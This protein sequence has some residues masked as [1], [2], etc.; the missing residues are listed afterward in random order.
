MTPFSIGDLLIGTATAALQI[1]GGDR[2]NNWYDW[3]QLPGAIKDGST[4][5]RA[6]DH[7]ARWREDTELMASLGLEV[8][9][10]GVEWSR[11]EPRP[12]EFDPA[13]I[14]HYRKEIGLLRE[15]G[16]APLVTLHHFT[17]PS[18][19]QGLGDWSHP[20]SV[21]IWLRFVRRVVSD[22]GDLVTEWVTL[23]EPNVYAVM[24]RLYG[25]FPPGHKSLPE[26]IKVMRHMAIAHCR[27]YE[28]IHE[29]QPHAT[30]GLAHHVRP[31]DPLKPVFTPMARLNSYLFQDALTDAV[32]GG[33]FALALGGQPKQVR[34]GKYYDYLGI[35]YYTRNAVVGFS[36][37]AFPN[38]PVNDLGWEIYPEGLARVAQDLHDRYPGPIWITENGT[39]DND[40]QFRARY[41]AEHLRVIAESKLPFERYYHWCF[42]DN[43]EW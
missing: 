10:M 40:E 8:Y 6:T 5:L 24:T 17:N 13:A 34:P 30:V 3:A 2:N 41:L 38:K 19:F 11:I 37:R 12:G 21:N 25:E 16:I 43:F 26:T 22:L 27:A 32:L 18:W 28:L 36:D 31:F 39:A 23:N 14:E 4:P 1:E 20:E 42:V 7:W 29:L 9:R 15:R 33:R 35:N